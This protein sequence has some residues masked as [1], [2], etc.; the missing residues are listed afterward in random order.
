[1]IMSLD[2]LL[3]VE[4]QRYFTFFKHGIEVGK[5]Q[6]DKPITELLIQSNSEESKN[7]PEVFQLFRPDMIHKDADGNYV[8]IE[9]N[10]NSLLNYSY[11]EFKL[12]KMKVRINPFVWNGCEIVLNRLPNGWD[13]FYDWVGKWIDLHDKK[14]RDKDGFQGVIHN[15]TFPK[16]IGISWE[17][18]ID[19]GTTQTEAIKELLTIF[20]EQG[21]DELNIESKWM[22]AEN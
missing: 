2:E 4:R 14:K 6:Y 13:C 11:A 20:E 12:G 9:Y 17:T 3:E 18:S 8:R 16:Q 19:L 21:V 22:G 10:L 7:L 1:M 15:A 5:S